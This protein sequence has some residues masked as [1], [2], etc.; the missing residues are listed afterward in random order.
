MDAYGH[1]GCMTLSFDI[2]YPPRNAAKENLMAQTVEMTKI[3]YP[4]YF[5]GRDGVDYTENVAKTGNALI[6]I[7]RLSNGLV[8]GRYHEDDHGIV[9]ENSMPDWWEAPDNPTMERFQRLKV[10]MQSPSLAVLVTR[11]SDSGIM[12][13]YHQPDSAYTHFAMQT[14]RGDKPEAALRDTFLDKVMGLDENTALTQLGAVYVAELGLCIHFFQLAGN[15]Y[16]AKLRER[17][18]SNNHMRTV[19]TRYFDS[20]GHHSGH[21]IEQEPDAIRTLITAYE[22]VRPD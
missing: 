9:V 18:L 7:L 15:N 13:E 1:V 14:F 16:L 2:A 12:R 5:T 10:R 11:M 20:S 19:L 22:K 6:I 8:T 17:K 3:A 21:A 4:H